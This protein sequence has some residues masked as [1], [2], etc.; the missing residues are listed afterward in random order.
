MYACDPSRFCPLSTSVSMP[1]IALLTETK[2]LSFSS[3]KYV[4][5]SLA[6]RCALP[7]GRQASATIRVW[8]VAARMLP[9]KL[10]AEA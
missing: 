9:V 2:S 7:R 6:E 3:W 1:P 4:A 8:G 10:V 5:V